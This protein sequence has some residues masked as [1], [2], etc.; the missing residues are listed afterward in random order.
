MLPD[1]TLRESHLTRMAAP[2][3][4][5]H[6]RKLKILAETSSYRNDLRR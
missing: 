4:G 6:T 3:I 2:T 1:E 5:T